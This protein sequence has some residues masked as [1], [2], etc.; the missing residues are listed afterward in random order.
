MFLQIFCIVSQTMFKEGGR[1]MKK[2]KIKVFVSLMLCLAL[3]AG[4]G[5]GMAAAQK[6]DDNKENTAGKEQEAASEEEK[7]AEE[8][9]SGSEEP[10]G[11]NDVAAEAEEETAEG[12]SGAVVFTVCSADDSRAFEGKEMTADPVY[13]QT[14]L[15]SE[16]YHCEKSLEKIE[17]HP[18]VEW[19][20][21][22]SS[23]TLSEEILGT[24][25]PVEAEEAFRIYDLYPEGIPVNCLVF[26]LEDRTCGTFALGYNGSGEEQTWECPVY[27]NYE[28]MTLSREAEVK[29]KEGE[30]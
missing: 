6:T 24:V 26:Y 13:L 10:A 22:F 5:S 19:A 2:Q 3:L 29:E 12:A 30:D 16:V 25:E 15:S 7:Q 9:D 11:E 14:A 20:E 28:T 18:I 27:K 4:C 17:V 8:E 21:D 1:I 23:F